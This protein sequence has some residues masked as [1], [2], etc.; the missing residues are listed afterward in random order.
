MNWNINKNDNN[1]WGS[2]GNNNP[3]GSGNGGSN[4][5]GDF[6]DSIK[7]A[8]DRF[9]KF[10]FGGRRNFS[11][12]FVRVDSTFFNLDPFSS[13]TINVK[14]MGGDFVILYVAKASA[15]LRYSR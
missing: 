5:R 4:N 12:F 2:G 10:K 1:P 8:R 6:E 14:A 3:W 11:I 7:K 15:F 13:T 9:G